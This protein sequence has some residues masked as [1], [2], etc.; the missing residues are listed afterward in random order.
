M[1]KIFF[2]LCSIFIIVSINLL[3][4]SQPRYYR[5]A[6][7]QM[8]TVVEVTVPNKKAAD[9]VFAR[10]AELENKLSIYK[11]ESEISRLNKDGRAVVSLDTLELIQL[12]KKYY[13]LTDGVFDVTV[14]PL[15]RLWGLK[16]KKQVDKIPQQAEIDAILPLIGCDKII[17]NE[18]SRQVSFEKEGME[19]D[20]GG[21]AKGFVVDE[22]IKILKSNGVKSALVV[23]GGDMYCLGKKGSKFWHVG[24]RNPRGAG[25]I[26]EL[27][28]ENAAITTSGGY[29]RFVT[30][31]GK[32][33]CHIIDSKS[34]YPLETINS[35]ATV[36][37]QS[38]TVAD[39]LSTTLFIVNKDKAAE[40]AKKCGVREYFLSRD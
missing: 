2:L 37:A 33:F 6:R 20:L 21:V 24:I 39:I 32:R 16:G 26:R 34:G 23:A 9:L 22:A 31:Q 5:E 14:L 1:K 15:S 3:Y 8:G 35:S 7:L 29:E 27:N 25:V 17:I 30:I 38:C 10:I 12:A 40:I 28:L 13:S 36:I 19:I 4:N 18:S 11:P